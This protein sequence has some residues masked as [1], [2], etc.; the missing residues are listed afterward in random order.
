MQTSRVVVLLNSARGHV[1]L[2]SDL[3]HRTISGLCN[4]TPADVG[5]SLRMEDI[6]R[7]HGCSF[8]NVTPGSANDRIWGVDEFVGDFVRDVGLQPGLI[9]LNAGAHFQE[10]AEL[11]PQ[12][13]AAL[14]AVVA[15][16]PDALVVWRNTP[17]GH[18]DCANMTSPLTEP[19]RG[20]L[21]FHWDEF[22]RQNAL[23]AAMIEREFPRVMYLDVATSTALRGDFHKSA[24]EVPPSSRDCMHYMQPGPQDEWV[25]GLYNVMR[26]HARAPA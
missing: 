12:V 17:P 25:R 9:V 5:G 4:V 22:A 24:F 21:P 26:A 7:T 10:D 13:Q 11:I 16:H 8:A 14:T 15:A 3:T 1:R 18:R 2:A 6:F 20:T 19:Q 23:I